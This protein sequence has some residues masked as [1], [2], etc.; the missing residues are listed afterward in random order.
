M[1]IR[2][3]KFCCKNF[4]QIPLPKIEARRINKRKRPIVDYPRDINISVKF[5]GGINHLECNLMII[6]LKLALRN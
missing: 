5:I 3:V 1:L 2:I 6:S 4:L